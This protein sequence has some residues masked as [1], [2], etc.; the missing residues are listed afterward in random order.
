MPNGNLLVSAVCET[1]WLGRVPQAS[2]LAAD[3]DRPQQG[4]LG[5]D[6]RG[7][8]QVE[9]CGKRAL[10]QPSLEAPLTHKWPLTCDWVVLGAAGLGLAW[11]WLSWPFRL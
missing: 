6:C 8:G 4:L 2:E 1:M 9:A 3:Q 5:F 10:R 11:T 7:E